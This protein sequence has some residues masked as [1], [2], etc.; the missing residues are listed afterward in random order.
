MGTV[1]GAGLGGACA[2]LGLAMM[3]AASP[4]T[5]GCTTHQCDPTYAEF[6]PRDDDGTGARGFMID[7]NT[8]VTSSLGGVGVA[9]K[10]DAAADADAQAEADANAE[11]DAE[12]DADAGADADADAEADADAGARS[13]PSWIGIPGNRTLHI[14]FPPEVAGR[15]PLAPTCFVANGPNPNDQNASTFGVTSTL[16]SGQLAEFNDVNTRFSS[17]N[18]GATADMFGGSFEIKNATCQFEYYRC[19]VDFVPLDAAPSDMDASADAGADSDDGA[20][21]DAASE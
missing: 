5:T 15:T 6:P 1:A 11:A 7:E 14:W 17:F 3:T 13:T 20:V 8:F 9:V 16:A 18:D 21:A 10:L 12:T 2:A 19:I 4:A